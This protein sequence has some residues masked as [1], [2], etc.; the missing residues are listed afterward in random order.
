[1][2]RKWRRLTVSTEKLQRRDA[3]KQIAEGDGYPLGLL[4]AVDFCGQQGHRPGVRIDR[5]I[6]Q[7]FIDEGL[8]AKPQ[9]GSLCAI[10]SVGEFR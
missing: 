5:Q 8:A 9:G 1:M 10:D 7:Q 6:A 2:S 3:D 4:L